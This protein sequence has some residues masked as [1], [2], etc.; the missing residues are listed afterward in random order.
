MNNAPPSFFLQAIY[1]TYTTASFS[2]GGLLFSII[3]ILLTAMLHGIQAQ[4]YMLG[5]C[6]GSYLAIG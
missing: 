4:W 1:A 5:L 2:F 3:A 6:L